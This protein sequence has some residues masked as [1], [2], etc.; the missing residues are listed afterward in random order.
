MVICRKNKLDE[1][2]KDLSEIIDDFIKQVNSIRTPEAGKRKTKNKKRK[3]KKTK[4]E[5]KKKKNK[6]RNKTKQKE[7]KQKETKQKEK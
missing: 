2:S 4:K 1:I 3:Q 7:T 5:N 6:K